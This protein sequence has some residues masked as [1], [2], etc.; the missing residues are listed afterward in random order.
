MQIPSGVQRILYALESAGFKAYCVGGC[1]RDFLLKIPCSDYDITTSATPKQINAALCTFKTVDTGSIHGTVTV[2]ADGEAVEVTTF[3]A[4]GQYSDHRH[5]DSVLFSDKLSCDLAR[6]DFTINSM[7]FHLE[8]GEI[9]D[10]YFGQKDLE[11]KLIRCTGSP[12]ERFEQDALRILR[13][14]R[15][16]ACLG[17]QIEENT[18]CAL[19]DCFSLLEYVSRE[20]ILS[21]LKKLVCGKCAGEVLYKYFK[22]FEHL[23]SIKNGREF[24]ENCRLLQELPKDFILRLSLLLSGEGEQGAREILKDLKSDNFTCDSA[25]TLISSLNT[26]PEDKAELKQLLRHIGIEATD[27]LIILWSTKGID[28]AFI[29]SE[30]ENILSLNECYSISGLDINGNDLLSLGFKGK[31]I[32]KTL[33]LLLDAVIEEKIPNRKPNLIEY[34]KSKK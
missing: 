33:N 23:L 7:A 31:Q 4:D 15:F 17:F 6:R 24:K 11:K 16:A 34:V 25:F 20:R 29:K 5:P 3:R 8:S 26:V 14:L 1:V 21:E 28:T 27:K 13:A 2:I 32:G 19:I 12:Y 18:Q 10:P 22:V 30:L 9:I